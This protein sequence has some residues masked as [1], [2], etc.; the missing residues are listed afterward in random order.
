MLLGIIRV[1][2][3]KDVYLELAIVF[4]IYFMIINFSKSLGEQLIFMFVAFSLSNIIS[5][6]FITGIKGFVNHPFIARI[7]G[8]P[9]EQKEVRI[10]EMRYLF[11][12]F[13]AF[14]IGS[15]VAG[16]VFSNTLVNEFLFPSVG[17][18]QGELLIS[19]I[20]TL[21]TYVQ[22]LYLFGEKLVNRTSMGIMGIII[23]MVILFIF[24]GGYTQDAISYF[25]TS[26]HMLLRYSEL[27]K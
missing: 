14:I 5:S 25:G 10:H 24:F 20:I 27:A 4:V 8:N 1:M 6:M 18:V 7:R 26:F 23:F 9:E 15:T 17:A 21:A 12:V 13:F 19:G 16:T 3:S 22:M 2:T 11:L